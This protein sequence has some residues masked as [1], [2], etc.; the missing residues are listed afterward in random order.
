MGFYYFDFRDA[1]KQDRR[2]M[3]ASLLVQ[4]SSRSNPCSD[5]LSR[6]YATHDNGA[7]MPSDHALTQSLKE[8]LQ[9]SGQGPIYIIIDAL[10][11][12]PNTSGLPNPRD[13]VLNL[14]EELVDL[15][16]PNVRVCVASRPEADIKGVLEGLTTLRVSLRDHDG[17]KQDI[18]DYVISIVRSDR[19]TRRWREEDKRLVIEVLSN[20]ANG[21]YVIMI[22]APH[23]R[24][25]TEFRRFRWV[26]CQLEELLSSVPES[27]RR[28][29]DDLP[30]PLDEMH[31]VALLRISKEKREY[32]FRLFQCLAVT[33]RPL[34]VEECAELLAVRFEADALPNYD[35]GW[36]L[37]GDAEEAVL[38][39]GSSLISVVKE[40]GIKV[41][42]FPHFSVKEYLASNRLADSRNDV[43]L[44]HISLVPAHTFLAKACLNVLLKLDDSIDKKT[45][46]NMPLALY[47]ARHWVDHAQFKNVSSYV[48]DMMEHL[49]D[50]D[51][52]HF[53]AWVWVHN[54]DHR[55]GEDMSTVH[56]TRPGAVPLYYA[57]LCGLHDLA[58]HLALACPS[59]V[60]ARGGYFMSP[61]RAALARGYMKV[62]AVLLQHGAEVDVQDNLGWT[63]LHWASQA[64]RRDIVK[65]LLEHNAD[66]NAQTGPGNTPLHL[67]S[68]EG[69]PGIA[70]LLLQHRAI[71]HY[72]DNKGWTSLHT[73]SNNGHLDVVQLLLESGAIVDARNRVQKTPL[74]LASM[75]GHVEVSR[76]LIERGADVNSRTKESWVPLHIAARFGHLDVVQLLLDHDVDVDVQEEDRWTS[77]H[78][79]SANGHLEVVELLVQRD[80]IVDMRNDKG[81]TPLDW[82]SAFGHLDIARFLIN[83]GANLSSRCNQGWTPF[84]TASKSGQLHITGLLIHSGVHVDV[85]NGNEETAL[86]LESSSE[87]PDLVHFLI[88]NGADTNLRD[89]DNKIPADL[90]SDHKK[91]DTAWHVAVEDAKI[92]GE[93]T[94][95][96]IAAE[97]GKI[98]VMQSL[99]ERGTDVNARDAN[100]NTPL[101]LAAMTGSVEMMRLLIERGAKV[102][103][104]NKFGWTPLHSASRYEHID[105]ARLLIDHGADINARIPE[106]WTPIHIL[107]A[108]GHLKMVELLLERGANVY[109]RNEEGRTPLE[110]AARRGYRNITQLIEGH[111]AR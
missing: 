71:V 108:N 82:A 62:A 59:D 51:K 105:V 95:L 83:H 5:I 16:L 32:A 111:V 91:L 64:G 81:E 100:H 70:R 2:G 68:G 79:A 66:V 90:V 88:E 87:E 41:V 17:Q 92:G 63:P 67:A 21:V 57:A 80:A 44:Y 25:L 26:V 73:A 38:S 3:L 97:E 109:D 96:H 50:P 46:K 12:C 55:W 52:H 101:G 18:V 10:N 13:Q 94:L 11:E 78:L 45:I 103:S 98:G 54:I 106:N 110:L 74:A 84:H 42:Q 93:Q 39:I 9:L 24:F 4:L 65:F 36:R 28:V 69:E 53:S 49:F 60:N 30:E 6:L 102:D 8:M 15:R 99:L 14:M 86:D 72:R 89:W 20:K 43:S 1:S 35:A 58:E 19:R 56:P 23:E 61:L 104:R 48:Q 77:L 85:R 7:R 47:A 27:I 31:E 40:D 37:R 29:L 22:K 75:N 33:V 34:R 107:A 76:F